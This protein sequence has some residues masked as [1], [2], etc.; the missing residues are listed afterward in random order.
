[1]KLNRKLVV[2][3]VIAAVLAGGTGAAMAVD[4]GGPAAPGEGA[5]TLSNILP[6]KLG[7][8]PVEQ[9]L[10]EVTEDDGRPSLTPMEEIEGSEPNVETFSAR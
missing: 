5:Q 10:D 2:A 1:M 3:G 7:D 8:G 6:E 9:G 4:G